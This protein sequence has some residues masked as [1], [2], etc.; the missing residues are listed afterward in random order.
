VA[1]FTSVEAI[2][3][4][5]A[6]R[7]LAHLPTGGIAVGLVEFLVFGLKQAWAC[8]FGGM[9]LAVILASAIL[10]PQSAPLARY[11]FLF[12]TAVAIQIAMLA[13][14][15]EQPREVVVIAA[16]HLIGTGM[17]LFKTS[18]GSWSYPE[19]AFFRIEGVPLFSGFMY[20]AVGS[21]LARI[22]RIF[23]LRCS[24]YP[25]PLLTGLLALSIYVNFFADYY[26]WDFRILL[27]AVTALLYGRCWVHFRVFKA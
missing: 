10:W 6:K 19:A 9:L 23:D 24:A 14:K 15:L 1:R 21:Y 12:L 27:F 3:D 26:G 22:T 17:E 11:D 25:R 16:F 5:R 2:I 8:L 7:L 20:G 18:H 13:L 4:D